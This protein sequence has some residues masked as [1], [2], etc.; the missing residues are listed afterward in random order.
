MR[1]M[2]EEEGSWIARLIHKAADAPIPPLAV[3][4]SVAAIQI[5]DL[6]ADA[7]NADGGDLVADALKGDHGFGAGFRTG[8]LMRR[9]RGCF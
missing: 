2:K 1:Q 3:F 4:E 6:P 8:M 9:G 5:D 7:F